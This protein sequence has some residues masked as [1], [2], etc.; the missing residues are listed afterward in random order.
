MLLRSTA[1]PDGECPLRH[2]DHW[3]LRLARQNTSD[4][5]HVRT[6]RPTPTRVTVAGGRC[7][8]SRVIASVHLPR[9][10]TVSQW[11]K[12]TG[13][14]RLQLRGQPWLN[15]PKGARTTF[16]FDP[17]REPPTAASHQ[18]ADRSTANGCWGRSLNYSCGAEA[19]WLARW[20][21]FCS[22]A[23]EE[24]LSAS[25]FAMLVDPNG[26]RA[27]RIA[28]S[29]KQR[30]RWE[31]PIGASSDCPQIYAREYRQRLAA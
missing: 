4:G 16:P 24:V 3:Q 18:D 13:A 27:R 2:R 21:G 6:P 25:C 31:F 11:R 15:E 5:R 23:C 22:E 10:T 20:T 7:P 26:Y 1:R 30:R 9:K 12:W 19:A 28:V 29:A 14:L 8:G 17:F